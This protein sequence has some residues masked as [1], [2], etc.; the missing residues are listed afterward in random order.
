M[1]IEI[2]TNSEDL[3]GQN[4]SEVSSLSEGMPFPITLLWKELKMTFFFSQVYVI[5]FGDNNFKDSVY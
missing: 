4:N 2:G 5:F 1:V 3:Y